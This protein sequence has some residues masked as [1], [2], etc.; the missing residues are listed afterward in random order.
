MAINV[1]TVHK[2][3]PD[4]RAVWPTLSPLKK[5]LIWMGFALFI[6]CFAR[7]GWSGELPFFLFKCRHCRVPVANYRHG[8]EDKLNCPKC[9]YGN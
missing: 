2:E 7:P 5:L 3:I 6:G 8:W 4:L 9:H 1:I